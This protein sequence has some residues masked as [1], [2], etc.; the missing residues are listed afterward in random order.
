MARSFVDPAEAVA[1]HRDKNWGVGR[2]ATHYGVQKPAIY[3]AF[4]ALK[5]YTPI[6]KQSRARSLRANLRSWRPLGRP[7][8]YPA[9]G[10]PMPERVESRE[11]CPRCNVRSDIGC[12]HSKAKLGWSVGR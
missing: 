10:L 1:L 5:Y 7:K 6:M 12:K 8:E 4:R 11:P 2:I 9:E 3:R